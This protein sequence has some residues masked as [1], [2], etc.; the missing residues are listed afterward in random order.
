MMKKLREKE[1]LDAPRRYASTLT[2]T[3]G[4]PVYYFD[5]HGNFTTL[6]Q[7]RVRRPLGG[8]SPP[9]KRIKYVVDR[10]VYG[11]SEKYQLEAGESELVQETVYKTVPYW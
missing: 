1:R 2:V 10:W 11:P 3:N 8:Q 7:E 4:A 9:K 6:G 5:T